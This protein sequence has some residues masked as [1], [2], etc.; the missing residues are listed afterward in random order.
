MK[1]ETLKALRGSI[2]KWDAIVDSADEFDNGSI[3]C[4]LCDLFLGEGDCL[5]CP[6]SEFT[7]SSGCSL[8]PYQTWASHL[9]VDHGLEE[10][11]LHRVE[12]CAKCLKLAKAERDFLVSLLPKTL[13]I[14][15]NA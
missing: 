15:D 1:P 9:A 13:S 8:T 7:G 12:G 5:G 14:G 3:N 2:A 6:V 4:P 10:H 11:P